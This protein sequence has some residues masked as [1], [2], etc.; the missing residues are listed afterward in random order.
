MELSD[1][2]ND[3]LNK[4]IVIIKNMNMTGQHWNEAVTKLDLARAFIDINA[5][6]RQSPLIISIPALH[7]IQA[8]V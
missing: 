6:L 3:L 5:L 8:Y 4:E 1:L 2:V 7:N